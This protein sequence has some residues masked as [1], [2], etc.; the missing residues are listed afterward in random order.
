MAK[1]K[2]KFHSKSID[3]V[4]NYFVSH[5]NKEFKHRIKA[6][7]EFHHPD[8]EI[9]ERLATH[10]DYVIN[11]KEGDSKYKGAFRMAD[12]S[13]HKKLKNDSD[14]IKNRKDIEDILE[15]Y[16]DTFLESHF[17][18]PMFKEKLK[19]AKA[20]GLSKKD[21]R[22]MKS[23]LFKQYLADKNGKP[24]DIDVFSDQYIN[25]YMGKSKMKIRSELK[26]LASWNTN[27]YQGHLFGKATGNLIK[28]HDEAKMS[29]YLRPIFERS[30]LKHKDDLLVKDFRTLSR[31]YA[32]YLST[33]DMSEHGY[34]THPK[35]K[36]K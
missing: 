28:Q 27:G 34:K 2:N 16:V 17:N 4:I 22:K 35:T 11:G 8:N 1:K 18:A 19:E 21:I 25:D 9:S 3:D 10:A 29:K 15:K 32:T 31:D 26:Q 33:G 7:E 12:G 24:I 6:Y 20:R 5:E 23:N 13:L 14:K 36:K 30:G